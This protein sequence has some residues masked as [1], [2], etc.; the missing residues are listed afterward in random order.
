MP[1]FE[2]ER[3]KE[4]LVPR[5]EMMPRLEMPRLEMECRKEVYKWVRTE[6]EV[7]RRG[8]RR[9]DGV[10]GLQEGED[11]QWRSENFR[12]PSAGAFHG[13]ALGEA[14]T[15]VGGSKCAKG[16]RPSVVQHREG[17]LVRTTP[18][19]NGARTSS[20]QDGEVWSTTE[21]ERSTAHCR[22][23]ASASASRTERMVTAPAAVPIAASSVST[24]APHARQFEDTVDAAVK[25]GCQ[26]T[27]SASS[28][29]AP[30]T[31]TRTSV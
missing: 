30:A 25:E 8:Y 28:V 2:M 16:Q 1:S 24:P 9:R 22:D 12:H 29:S 14:V 19:R 11:W 3:R 13:R 20:I 27:K 31:S 21:R 10:R 17:H 6:G 5:F 18:R 26:G 4:S 7:Y 15:T 23:A